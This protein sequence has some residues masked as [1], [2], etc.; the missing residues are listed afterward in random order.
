[1][2]NVKFIPI[3]KP[4]DLHLFVFDLVRIVGNWGANQMRTALLTM[5]RE[6]VWL[7]AK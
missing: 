3:G 6:S 5:P 1:M 2:L 4:Y 7:T